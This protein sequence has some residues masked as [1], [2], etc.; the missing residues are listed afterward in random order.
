[1]NTAVLVLVV[2]ATLAVVGCR[3]P[4]FAGESEPGPVGPAAEPVYGP[5]NPTPGGLRSMQVR[6]F[7]SVIGLRPE[8][9]AYY[10][11][12]HANVWPG[13][14]ERLRK[15][16]IRN[17]S[18]YAAEIEGKRYLFSYFEYVG[19]DYKA[20]MKAMADDPLTRTWWQETDPCQIPLPNRSPGAQW[21]DLEMVFL[22]E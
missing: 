9:E 18:I 2:A 17:Y 5:T 12:L 7:G 3:S 13:V 8:K 6:R 20:D 21:S 16:H 10:R 1:M 14:V 15:S 4:R 19:E 22:M 11:E